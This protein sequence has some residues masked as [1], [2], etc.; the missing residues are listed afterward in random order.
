MSRGRPQSYFH[1]RSS[2]K[3][4]NDA[5]L[6]AACPGAGGRAAVTVI[7]GIA[8]VAVF[9]AFHRVVSANRLNQAAAIATIP[10]VEVSIVAGLALVGIYLAI[11]AGKGCPAAIVDG[12]GALIHQGTGDCT[13][14]IVLTGTAIE[15][16]SVLVLCAASCTKK[17]LGRPTP[18]SLVSILPALVTDEGTQLEKSGVAI[19]AWKK[20]C[21][22]MR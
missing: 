13:S 7:G 15:R 20:T 12:P 10:I 8:I 2:Q 3:R 21:T 9:A 22:I 16:D 6:T 17:A 18:M 4:L 5:I 1:H 19:S 14:R 11:A